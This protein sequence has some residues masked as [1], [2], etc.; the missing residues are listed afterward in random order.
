M[1]IKQ[2]FLLMKIKRKKNLDV[3]NINFLLKD[4]YIIN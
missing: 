2:L 3:K 1:K 4:I